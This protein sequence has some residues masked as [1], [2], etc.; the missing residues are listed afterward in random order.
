LNE[1]PILLL[2]AAPL[3]YGLKVSEFKCERGFVKMM[4][5]IDMPEVLG[6]VFIIAFNIALICFALVVGV[7]VLRATLRL[8]PRFRKWFENLGAEATDE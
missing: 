8:C 3:S 6:G 4:I 2:S 5:T 1:P 7:F